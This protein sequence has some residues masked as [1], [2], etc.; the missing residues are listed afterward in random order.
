MNNLKEYIKEFKKAYANGLSLE[1]SHRVALSLVYS[2][3][4]D[5]DLN[6]K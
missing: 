5:L 2:K 4:K 6:Q 3:I 1:D